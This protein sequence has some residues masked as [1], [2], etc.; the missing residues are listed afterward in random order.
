MNDCFVGPFAALLQE[1]VAFKRSMGYKYQ[2]ESNYLKQFSEFSVKEGSTTPLLTKELSDSWCEKRPYEHYR[3]GT[4]QRISC[5]RQFALYLVSVG[6][7]AHIPI[8]TDNKPSRK[9]K[10]VAYVFTHSEID[11]II[12]Q[13]DKIFPHRRSTMHLVMPVLTRLLYSTGL[14][15]M[16]A[17]QLQLKNVDLTNGILRIE[18]AKFDKDR[19][20]PL[21]SSMLDV[22]RQYCS[23][24]HPCLFPEDFLF[25][26]ITRKPYTHHDIYLRFRELLAQ[27]GIPHAGRGNGPRIHDVRHTFCCHTLQKAVAD[28]KDLNAVM[29]V[30][31]EYLGHESIIATSQYLKM[32]AE[33][34]PE[35]KN[36]VEKV[37][38]YVIPEV[39]IL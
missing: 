11:K 8:H 4:Q 10:Y 37:C 6:I 19:L 3:N 1:F 18:H 16:E 9:S 39:K 29:P 25:I 31:S 17:L 20:I 12:S 7:Q 38:A 30:L 24:M 33:V 21:S 15:I 32:T 22:L 35:V 23:V 14:R 13:S 26:G 2:K 27:S 28:G 5:L 34:Y 36:A